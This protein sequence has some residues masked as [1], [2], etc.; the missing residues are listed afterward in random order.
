MHTDH[1]APSVKGASSC[2]HDQAGSTRLRGLLL[3][4]IV[5]LLAALVLV[6]ALIGR[7]V[8]IL[9]DH[10]AGIVFPARDAL[11]ESQAVLTAELAAVRG[12]QISGDA[13]YVAR[14]QDALIRE[15]EAMGR[16]IGLASQ[17][18][19]EVLEAVE[20]FRVQSGNW[21]ARP[22]ALL[23]G[24]IT[25]DQLIDSL[26][27][28]QRRFE[29][30]LSAAAEAGAALNRSEIDL[31]NRIQAAM[32]LER[33]LTI[34]LAFMALSAGLV[35][36]WLTYRLHRLS[37]QLEARTE[38][39]R[40]S[41]ERFRLIAENLREMIWIS[42]PAYTF[43]YYLSPAYERIWGRSTDEARN[44]PRSFLEA[45]VPVDRE[46]VEA[47]LEGYACGKYA[48]EYRIVR[49]DGEVRWISGRSYPVRDDH[50]EVFLVAGIAEDITD[51]KRVE[52]E[53]E[54]LL[55]RERHAH[56]ITDAALQMRD[57]V[58]RIVSHDLRN[59][60]HMI[61]MAAELLEMPLPEQQREKQLAVIR[62]TVKRAN[63]LV[64]DLL[65]AARIESGQAVAVYPAPLEVRPL[66]A[67]AIE[68]FWFEAEEKKQ[69]LTCEAADGIAPVLADHDRLFQALSNLLGNAVKFTPRG[70][71][72]R[73]RAE[74]AANDIV[75]FC[76]SD[77]GPG[78]S[79]EILPHLFDPFIQA[80]DTASL[81]TGLG[82]SI[83]R[84]IVEAHGGN[85]TVQSEHDR[86]TTF[87]FTI[88][89]SRS[90]GHDSQS[91]AQLWTQRMR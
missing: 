69:Q 32:R 21:Q 52:Q 27:L 89:A 55:E 39:L 33:L 38:R 48:A 45:V 14:L 79:A 18:G 77:T 44:N 36:S 43:Q 87:T 12:Y 83:T 37:Q 47:A 34:L 91:T 46:R 16:L 40:V 13:V 70:G 49:P 24:A 78:I 59:P 30:A 80:K 76:V 41:E 84:G 53:L 73:I 10:R 9:R 90:S 25:R 23:S 17:L 81:G 20:G 50:G 54:Q 65:D 29:I 86:G 74:M 31:E 82:L 57:R 68:P 1:I 64:V 88:P 22:R 66:L 75:R 15:R 5:L 8:D 72:I 67:E 61:G 3:V 51:Q 19:P 58:L 7:R 26:P 56:A 42:D 62:H 63:R 35:L 85:I 28:E 11:Q 6:P 2:R 4:L 60:L 71:H